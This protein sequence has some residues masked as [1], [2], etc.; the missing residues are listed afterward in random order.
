[1]F[2]STTAGFTPSAANRIARVK[3]G[4]T[5]ADRGAPAGTYHYLVR[6]V[7]KAGNLG[8]VSNQASPRWPAT[9]PPRPWRSPRRRTAR[10]LR[11]RVAHARRRPTTSASRASSSSS[12]ART[13]ARPDTTSP[14]SAHLGL[15]DGDRR[16]AHADRRRARRRPATRR[17]RQRG[18]SRVHNT[19]ARRR[20]RLRGDVRHD[21]DGPHQRL[22]RRDHRRDAR[23][24]RALRPGAVVRRHRRLG[25]GRRPRRARPDWAAARSRPGS[26]RGARTGARS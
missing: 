4:T 14:Y 7:D 2:R 9:R 24:R 19:G 13:S 3:T 12:T 1:M 26:A 10:R 16:P 15:A 25:D 11:Q 22:Q 8:P 20:L 5:Y 6:A 21:R 18:P 17:P 23:D